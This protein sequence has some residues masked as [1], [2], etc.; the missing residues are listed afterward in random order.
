M[1][2]PSS[3]TGSATMH[4]L[5]DV[6]A[7][8]LADPDI[9]LLR[10]RDLSSALVSLGRGL[11]LPLNTISA[12]P[13]HL[14]RV[15]GEVTP[16]MVGFSTGRW[17]NIRSLVEA[18]LL[19]VGL[20]AIPTRAS[21]P[22]TPAWKPL[23]SALPA[24]GDR[25]RLGR[26][27]RYCIAAS[28]LPDAVDDRVFEQFHDDL[29]QR[30]LVAQPKRVHRDTVSAWNRSGDSIPSWPQVRFAVPDN[31]ATYVVPWDRYPASLK[32]DFDRWLRHLAGE[33]PNYD[34]PDSPGT[35]DDD[36][37]WQDGDFK[38]L[39]P[40]S[41][42]TRE[43]QVRSF[44]AAMVHE[45]VDPAELHTLADA[46]KPQRAAAAFKFL[47]RRAGGQ[48]SVNA[49]HILG[50]VLSIAKH[51]VPLDEEAVNRLKGMRKRVGLV[52]NCMTER[53]RLAVLPL[54]DPARE[55]EFLTLPDRMATE[56]IRAGAPT[57]QTAVMIEILT[58]IPLRVL[59]LST[60]RIGSNLIADRSGGMTLY[61][62]YQDVKNSIVIEARLPPCTVKLLNLYTALYR[63]LLPGADSAWLFPG[64]K[65][66]TAK[67]TQMVRTQISN[68]MRRRCGLN[69]T[70]HTFRAAVGK[71]ILMH[72]PG[73]HGL[74]QQVLSHKSIKTTIAYY[75]GTE[76]KASI[77]HW[78]G[79]VVTARDRLSRD[80][81]SP[82]RRRA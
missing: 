5:A 66:G 26:F 33:E 16:A 57:L 20:I 48:P 39:R 6:H 80:E 46:V 9:G 79:Y 25:Y 29:V 22:L 52:R 4:N 44:L 61:I 64:K 28:V 42:R 63:P 15:L 72:N 19:H 68:C 59:N 13:V 40:T 74:V 35:G 12:D 45:G 37:A 62:P 77:A 65:A 81:R 31:R 11:H 50:T 55:Q 8:V 41:V 78:D 18:S 36:P 73:A 1:N 10:R 3:T 7:A 58:M 27:A 34:G 30:S 32:V 76:G 49:G 71:I 70:P 69:F 17:R 24:Y 21:Q 38:P 51:R 47:R 43:L 23:V 75:T 53:T 2:D 82:L 56:V 14:R 67:S 60:L 54:E